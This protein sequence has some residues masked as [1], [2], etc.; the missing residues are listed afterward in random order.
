MKYKTKM[1]LKRLSRKTFRPVYLY[2]LKNPAIIIIFILSAIIGCLLGKVIFTEKEICICDPVIIKTELP[3]LVPIVTPSPK[4]WTGKVSFYS[5]DGCL[6][7]NKLQIT[8][9][10]EVFDEMANTL[11]FNKLPL[12]TKV[13]VTNL[14]TGVSQVAKVNDRGG[15]EKYNR[16]ADLS[17]GLFEK[18]EAKTDVSNIKIEKYVN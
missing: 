18:L 14:D 16:I 10:G 2:C 15:F 5:K 8:A 4:Q 3:K 6:G 9:S 17:K 12:N 11:A 1:L 13:L 7:C